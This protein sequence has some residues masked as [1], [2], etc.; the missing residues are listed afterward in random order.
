MEKDERGK[1]DRGGYDSW[2]VVQ[3]CS[4]MALLR[5]FSFSFSVLSFVSV[6]VF[7]VLCVEVLPLSNSASSKILSL[8]QTTSQLE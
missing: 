1:A 5:C 3:S 8:F 6:S 7:P 2:G 4:K